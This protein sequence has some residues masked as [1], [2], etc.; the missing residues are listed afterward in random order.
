MSKINILLIEDNEGDIFLTQEALSESDIQ[1][2][3]SIVKDGDEALK[4]LNKK[5]PYSDAEL[6]ELILLDINLPKVNG[7]EVLKNIKTSNHLK[8]LPVIMLTTST[9]EDDILT[10]Y[11]NYASCY[12]PKP[13]DVNDFIKVIDSIKNFWSSIVKLPKK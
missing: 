1:S 7:H 2:T 5:G 10:C 3:L 8:H 4:F 11:Q 13:M 6:P 12:I 9:S